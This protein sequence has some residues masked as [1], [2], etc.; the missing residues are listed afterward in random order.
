MTTE[1]IKPATSFWVVAILALIWNGMGV[2]AYLGQVTMGEEALQAMPEEQRNLLQSTPAWAT[3]A[4]ALAVW[5]GL[6]GSLLLLM[7]KKLASMVFIVSFAGIVVQM[8]HAFFLSNSI[9]VY[10]P[11]GMIMPVM[12]LAFGAYL[13]YFSRNA[14]SKG[15]LQ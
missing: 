12:V 8:S 3:G 5:G 10:G 6:L 9:E 15:V 11:G 1:Q 4:F 7:R 2:A 13:I 14:A